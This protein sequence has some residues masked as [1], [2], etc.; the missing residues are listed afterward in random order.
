MKR[1]YVIAILAIFALATFGYAQ[2]GTVKTPPKANITKTAPQGSVPD[3]KK[4]P[5]MPSNSVTRLTN[6]LVKKYIT[7]SEKL[8]GLTKDEKDTMK[9]GTFMRNPTNPVY[10][11]VKGIV[12]A[13]GFKGYPEYLNISRRVAKGYQTLLESEKPKVTPSDKTPGKSEMKPGEIKDRSKMMNDRL[14]QQL[15]DP[16]LTPEQKEKMKKQS[17]E[18]VKQQEERMKAQELNDDEMKVIK[19]SRNE[20]KA[21]LDKGKAKSTK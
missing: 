3:V 20:L 1:F 6:D 5:P 18:R 11:K 8:E 2:T 21:I 12:E 17:E 15:N 14:Q 13:A 16:K 4:V 7:V 10:I 19:S 9:K